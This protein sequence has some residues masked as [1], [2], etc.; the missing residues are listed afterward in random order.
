ME[1]DQGLK[2]ISTLYL[3]DGSKKMSKITI[4]KAFQELGKIDMLH[5][6]GKITKTEHNKRSKIVLKKLVGK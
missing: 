1:E 6:K 3:V 5:E 4:T 2:N